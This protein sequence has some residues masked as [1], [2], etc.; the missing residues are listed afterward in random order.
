MPECINPRGQSFT[1]D[2]PLPSEKS[3]SSWLLYHPP[4]V[5]SNLSPAVGWACWLQSPWI[6]SHDIMNLE[7]QRDF[8]RSSD[9][10]PTEGLW[11]YNIDNREQT[12]HQKSTD[13]TSFGNLF[14]VRLNW[15]PFFESTDTFEKLMKAM[16]PFGLPE[17]MH[18]NILFAFNFKGTSWEL[19]VESLGSRSLKLTIPQELEA[20][21]LVF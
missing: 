13:E 1:Q 4:S 12:L 7:L 6:R 17:K 5:T 11:N 20:F 8:E 18:I 14:S 21:A 9:W 19:F 15:K 10:L 2:L 3:Y 16:A